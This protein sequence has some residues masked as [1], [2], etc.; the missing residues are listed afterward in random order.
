VE[1]DKALEGGIN[2]IL[3]WHASYKSFD[4]RRALDIYFKTLKNTT[5]LA[6]VGQ[7]AA[8]RRLPSN[9]RLP[10]GWTRHQLVCESLVRVLR[11]TGAELARQVEITAQIVDELLEEERAHGR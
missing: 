3:A 8:E 6:A 10:Y 7:L 11:P 9:G 2:L 4:L 5:D 1:A